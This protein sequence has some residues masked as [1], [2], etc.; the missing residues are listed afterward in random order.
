M[1]SKMMLDNL[2]SFMKK[3]KDKESEQLF[4]ARLQYLFYRDRKN[5]IKV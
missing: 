5:F 2:N 1:Q 4:D 3:I